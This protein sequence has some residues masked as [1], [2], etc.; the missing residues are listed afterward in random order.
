MNELINQFYQQGFVV[1]SNPNKDF[2]EKVFQGLS[3]SEIIY[4]DSR[5]DKKWVSAT[6]GSPK[7]LVAPHLVYQEF[8]QLILSSEV[9]SFISTLWGET[10]VYLYN[11]KISIKKSFEKHLWVPH[12]DSAYK[13]R[14][15][16]GITIC[17]FLE[18]ADE[19]N[20]TIQVFPESHKLGK[21]EHHLIHSGNCAY[22]L[23]IKN[24]PKIEPI[25]V[26]A[27]AGDILFMSSNTI[28]QS[29]ENK[30]SGVRPIF[31]FEIETLQ[32]FAVDE[33]GKIPLMIQ[34]QMNKFEQLISMLNYQLNPDTLM[35]NS[36]SLGRKILN[37]INN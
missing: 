9:K 29:Q 31:I 15:V 2:L 8:K 37:K 10:R 6:S 11:S 30:S 28:H 19:S 7:H 27:K 12:Q 32:K 1:K 16:Q 14:E 22:Q 18:D 25:P 34:G 21:L 24:L 35:K 3:A 33:Y 5:I 26:K 13:P 23:V 36:K 17:I 4:S 20:G